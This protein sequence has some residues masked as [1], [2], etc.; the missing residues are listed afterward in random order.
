MSNDSDDSQKLSVIIFSHFNDAKSPGTEIYELIGNIRYNVYHNE[1]FATYDKEKKEEYIAAKILK[2][3]ELLNSKTK[4]LYYQIDEKTNEELKKYFKNHKKE[5][6]SKS[7]NNSLGN[8]L[9]CKIENDKIII[10]DEKNSCKA[11]NEIKI[12]TMYIKRIIG[13]QNK[14][15]IIEKENEIIIYRTKNNNYEI[16]QKIKKDSEGFKPQYN[17]IFHDCT[18]DEEK[19]KD[20]YFINIEIISENR[21]FLISNYGFKLYSL[22]EKNE[23][24][25]QSITSYDK[26]YDKEIKYFH[27][28]NKNKF[29]IGSNVHCQMSDAGPEHDNFVI[30]T[31]N[32]S[33][34]INDKFMFIDEIIEFDT[35]GGDTYHE[36]YTINGEFVLNNRYYICLIDYYL[37]IYDSFEDAAKKYLIGRDGEKTVYEYNFATIQIKDN[38]NNEFLI[39]RGEQKTLFKI[40]GN[41]LKIIGYYSGKYDVDDDKNDS[42]LGVS[43]TQFGMVREKNECC[44][45]F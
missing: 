8:E 6:K 45:L 41:E 12:N 29:V 14:D 26:P 1:S 42:P 13:L 17:I 21:F 44:L 32:I 2:E 39:K 5:Q 36:F 18:D 20:Y 37:I 16:L 11:I 7:N 33:P 3:K 34:E 23:Y 35:Y 10:Y 31:L 24:S 19:L 27:E 9:C 40:I 4:K 28:I 38:K 15:L 22:N 30:D 25:L 43:I